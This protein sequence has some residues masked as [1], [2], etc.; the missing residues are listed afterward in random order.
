MRTTWRKS[1]ETGDV[2]PVLQAVPT[3]FRDLPKTPLAISLAKTDEGRQLIEVGLHK[4][5]VFSRPFVLPPGTPKERV[6][7][8]VKAFQETLTEDKEFLGEAEKAGLDIE[9]ASADDLQKAVS[10][11]FEM[12]PAL[13]A[14]LE[15][16]LY[17]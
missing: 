8:L 16:V 17:K 11:I 3:P 1:L 4:S 12:A 14:R 5:G 10:G 7:I 9:F 13:V 6:Q 15:N 2:I